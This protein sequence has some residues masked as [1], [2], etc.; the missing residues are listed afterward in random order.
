M[1]LYT[2]PRFLSR[3]AGT[4]SLTLRSFESIIRFYEKV[5]HAKLVEDISSK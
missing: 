3:K 5:M 4:L 1:R 2:R